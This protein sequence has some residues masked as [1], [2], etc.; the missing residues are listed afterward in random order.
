MSVNLVLHYSMLSL[1]HF[2]SLPALPEA[3]SVTPSLPVSLCS[4]LCHTLLHSS[5]SFP[6]SL[7]CS[8]SLSVHATLPVIIRHSQPYFM[9]LPVTFCPFLQSLLAAAVLPNVLPGFLLVCA[10][11]LKESNSHI[12][13]PLDSLHSSSTGNICTSSFVHGATADSSWT[14][15]S[16]CHQSHG[17]SLG[18]ILK[19][20][21]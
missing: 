7:C 6:V 11:L 20:I 9:S 19:N 14:N 12:H 13:F 3:L 2:M 18:C 1:H 21:H 10:N 17:F 8:H 16:N 15:D 5:S 4:T